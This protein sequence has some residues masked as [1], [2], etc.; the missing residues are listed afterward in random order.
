MSTVKRYDLH[1]GLAYQFSLL[2]QI[3]TRRMERGLAELGLTRLMW[4]VLLAVI[5]EGKENPSDIAEF[6]GINRTA[7]SRTF[8]QMEDRGLISRKSSL[9]DRR[10]TR[11]LATDKGHELL[12]QAIPHAKALSTRIRSK[13]SQDEQKS[14][15]DIL[16]KLLD[17]ER[18][19]VS[20]L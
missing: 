18:K 5:E 15:E 9:Q 12:T 6:I 8:R 10:N 17:G 19:E 16:F 13:L 20:S 14:L 11:L 3:N 7:A 4:C 2:S 1:K